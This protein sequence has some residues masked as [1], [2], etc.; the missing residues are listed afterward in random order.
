MSPVNPS[1]GSHLCRQRRLQCRSHPQRCGTGPATAQH[2]HSHSHSRSHSHS[3]SRSHSHNRRLL[4]CRLVVGTCVPKCPTW[5]GL[6][7]S[8]TPTHDP[9]NA[10]PLLLRV[11]GPQTHTHTTLSTLPPH[12]CMCLW[13][14]LFPCHHSHVQPHGWLSG[15]SCTPSCLHLAGCCAGTP[16]HPCASHRLLAQQQQPQRIVGRRGARG[17]GRTWSVLSGRPRRFRV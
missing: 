1:S 15:P 2:S 3:H 9:V 4:W 5:N 12:C 14:P 13:T 17:T 8:S 10:G 16:R 11:S 7:E 6:H